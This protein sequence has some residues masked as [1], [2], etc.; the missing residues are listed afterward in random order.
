ML[1]AR[2]A[3][4]S[5]RRSASGSARSICS[6][7]R[8]TCWPGF[9]EYLR[10]QHRCRESDQVFGST[11]PGR[12]E[13][14]RR[15]CSSGFDALVDQRVFARSSIGCRTRRELPLRAQIAAFPVAARLAAPR[16]S[17]T[18]LGA[19]RRSKT[20]YEHRGAGTRR[21]S[22]FWH[23]DRQPGRSHP[24]QRGACPRSA[25]RSTRMGQRP[26]PISCGVSSP[27]SIFP[28][29]RASRGRNAGRRTEPADASTA[30]GLA[31]M[32][33][34]ALVRR[35]RAPGPTAIS[36]T[37]RLI[38]RRS[39]TTASAY[40]D[41]AGLSTRRHGYATPTWRLLRSTCS[42][43]PP[44]GHGPMPSDFG[45]G[46]GQGGRLDSELRRDLRGAICSTAPGA[47]PRQPRRRTGWGPIRSI[48]L[49][50]PLRRPQELPDP[51]PAAARWTRAA[52]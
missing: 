33:S 43:R 7:R 39:T 2:L 32:A 19:A 47:H 27:T 29:R 18:L 50:R 20:R 49:G 28:E 3:T 25:R 38:R 5:R 44:R 31:A 4:R 24:P 8:P 42:A 23:A 1:R 45:L 15:Q 14:R 22:R 35:A 11:A 34:S 12:Q 52:R 48:A 46:L 26:Q 41:A 17:P 13:Q 40:S 16:R 9:R 37:W 21:L 10:A 30:L 36:R 51:G 6:S